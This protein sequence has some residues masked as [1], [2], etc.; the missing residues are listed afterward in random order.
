[1]ETNRRKGGNIRMKGKRNERMERER[2]REREIRKRKF[3][4]ERG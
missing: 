1:M 3:T 2:E 4:K